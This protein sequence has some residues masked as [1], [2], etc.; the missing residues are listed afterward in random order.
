M[1]D[2]KVE[3]L[4]KSDYNT[5]S[6]WYTSRGLQAPSEE[7]YPDVGFIVSGHSAGFFYATS[8]SVCLIEGFVTNNK[9]PLK[10]RSKALDLIVAQCLVYAKKCGFKYVKCDTRNAA[11]QRRA[12]KFGFEVT[13]NYN[14]LMRGL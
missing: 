14:S 12:Q 4:N 5:I 8:S 9:S 2:L 7:I 11:I 10:L 3:L 13:G 6:S 1:D